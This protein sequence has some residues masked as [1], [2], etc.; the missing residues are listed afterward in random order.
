MRTPNPDISVAP[1]P[2]QISRKCSTCEDEEKTLQTKPAGSPP[3]AVSRDAS[4]IIRK[5]LRCPGQPLDASTRAFMEPRFGYDFSRVRVHA[6][7][8]AAESAEM[9]NARA[10]TVRSDV[11]FAPQMYAPHSREGQKLLAHELVHV[12]QQG[13]GSEVTPVSF[14]PTKKTSALRAPDGVLRFGRVTVAGSAPIGIARQP[15]SSPVP[16]TPAPAGPVD[17]PSPPV[18]GSPAEVKLKAQ[19]IGEQW[20]TALADKDIFLDNLQTKIGGRRS[21]WETLTPAQ[22][23]IQAKRFQDDFALLPRLPQLDQPELVAAQDDG[24]EA[25]VT[26]GY[27]LE[28]F[29]GFLVKLGSAIA[30]FLFQGLAARGV[31][32]PTFITRGL[33]GL[34]GALPTPPN[35]ATTPADV[36]ALLA[37]VRVQA[38]RVV[39]NIGGR[40]APGE[41][42]NAININPEQL[43][44]EIPNH[45]LVRGEEMDK[46]LPNGS[47][48]EV[49][50]RNLVG[51]IN[52]KEMARAAKVVVKP[53]GTV[54]LSP[55][56]GQL[57]EL[58]QIQ[59]AMETAGLKNVRVEFG[60]VVKGER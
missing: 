1:A 58:P 43:R 42:A 22:K 27:S 11:A 36:A 18:P 16:F 54:T 8:A 51:D 52:W 34:I 14:A 10:Y 5:V 24:F 17:I 55:W 13:R 47:G 7:A 38:G 56:G 3:E 15:Q 28:K 33:R 20:G 32:L 45:V 60:S 23:E 6:D 50:S 44:E 39:Y 37:R 46:L 41:P 49:F 30:I 4:D 19:K 25:G 2:R 40:A 29:N 59:T 9:I 35:P 12:V 31:R 48:D 57:G 53:G 21:V 26:I